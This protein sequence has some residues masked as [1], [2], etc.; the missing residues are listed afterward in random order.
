MVLKVIMCIMRDKLI[1]YLNNDLQSGQVNTRTGY[2]ARDKGNQVQIL[3]GP[4]T[5]TSYEP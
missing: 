1:A 3:N 2:P 4:A 5:V